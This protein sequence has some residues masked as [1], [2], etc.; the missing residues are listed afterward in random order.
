[1]SGGLSFHGDAQAAA[2]TGFRCFS[3][4]LARRG[5]RCRDEVILGDFVGTSTRHPPPAM[6]RVWFASKVTG[7]QSRCVGRA[8]FDYVIDRL[9]P[10]GEKMNDMLG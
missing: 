2:L 4:R 10:I 7:S 5:L 3:R 6:S 1:M 9:A 8:D